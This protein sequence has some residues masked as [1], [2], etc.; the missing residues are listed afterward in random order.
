MSNSK[1]SF[2]G[3][4]LTITVVAFVLTGLIGTW[5]T[6]SLNER[7]QERDRFLQ[8]TAA[9][10]VAVQEFARTAYD[11]WTRANMLQSSLLR[12][13]PLDELRNRKTAYDEAYA[14][15]NRDLQANLFMIRT[16]T[17]SQEYTNFEGD[18][19][20][21]LTPIFRDIDGCLTRAYDLRIKGSNAG[22][23][24]QRCAIDAKFTRALNCVYA[25]TDQLFRVAVPQAPRMSSQTV[26]ARDT[27]N[28]EIESKC[29]SK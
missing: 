11:R 12:N 13:A 15:W 27:A 28:A 4:P 17:E 22:D 8:I 21:R 26:D 2:L 20:F 24:L 10:Q 7:Q 5:F 18:V 6:K 29:Q 9:R 1:S 3:H 25:V 19:E 14:H 16:A 23:A